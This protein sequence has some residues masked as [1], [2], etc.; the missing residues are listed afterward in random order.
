[1]LARAVASLNRPEAIRSAQDLFCIGT[2]AD[3][4]PLTGANRV[5][6]LDGLGRLHRS[7]CEGLKALLRLSGL[8]E[9]PLT[10]E[11]IGFQLAP[12][13]NAVGRLGEPSLVVDLLTAV[14]EDS[15]MGLARR[16]DDFNRQRRDLCEAIEAEAL[17]LVEADRVDQL[18]P[19]LLLAQSIGTTA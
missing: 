5:W 4:A 8:G 2:V 11:D 15:A 16:C 18:P 1:M 10:A 19:F 9:R 17:A 6:L 13:I 12:R 14:D 3:M 7:E